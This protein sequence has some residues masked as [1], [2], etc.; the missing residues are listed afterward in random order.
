MN[1]RILTVQDL[2]IIGQCSLG[3][4]LPIISSMGIE[5]CAL[6]SSVLSTHTAKPFGEFVSRDLT[7]DIK[8]INEH[9]QSI[10]ATFD[11]ILTGYIANPNQLKLIKNLIKTCLSKGAKIIIDPVMGDGGVKYS[12]IT[13]KMQQEMQKFI[14]GAD[15]ILPNITEAYLLTNR[16]YKACPLNDEIEEILKQLHDMSGGDVILTGVNFMPGKIG[17]AYYSKGEINYCFGEK[18][19]GTYHGAGDILASFVAAC[20]VKGISLKSALPEIIDFIS[21]CIKETNLNDHWYGIN[22]EQNLAQ[23]C[24]DLQK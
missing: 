23:F 20:I 4:A 12:Q 24:C 13:D 14:K 6:P 16:K 22:Y 21:T 17:V 10:G 5:T 9:W 11:G 18:V 2:S 1:K 3:V 15:L 7:D 19:E 8:G